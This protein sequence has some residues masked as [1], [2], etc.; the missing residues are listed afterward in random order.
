MAISQDAQMLEDRLNEALQQAGEADAIFSTRVD[1]EAA[2]IRVRFA[3]SHFDEGRRVTHAILDRYFALVVRADDGEE[4]LIGEEDAGR[5]QHREQELDA[6]IERA[7]VRLEWAG[8]ARVRLRRSG[9]RLFIDVPDRS[10]ERVRYAREIL[11]R[12]DWVRFRDTTH[13]DDELSPTSA[14]GDKLQFEDVFIGFGY[15]QPV[16]CMRLGGPQPESLR[17]PSDQML[18]LRLMLDMREIWRG[19]GFLRRGQG[20]QLCTVPLGVT[21]ADR[22]DHAKALLQTLRPATHL[23]LR[24][25]R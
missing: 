8:L 19:A 11:L 18:K 16:L 9:D 13:G 14:L 2:G 25:D 21:L 1:A 3:K 20:L 5:W 6:V 17:F 22:L 23:P 7:R 4:L 24:C 10:S 15:E 12:D